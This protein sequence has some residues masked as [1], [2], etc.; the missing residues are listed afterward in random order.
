MT[1]RCIGSVVECAGAPRPWPDP[2]QGISNADCVPGYDWLVTLDL[3]RDVVVAV[4]PVLFVLLYLWWRH[5]E[6]RSG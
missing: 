6:R 2:C 5:S 1:D 3:W 4:L